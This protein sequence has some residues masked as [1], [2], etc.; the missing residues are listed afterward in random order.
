MPSIK[1]LDGGH[2]R[3]QLVSDIAH[4]AA[5]GL[6]DFFQ[7]A[8]HGV[9]GLGQLGQ[10]IVALHGHAGG[11]ISPPPNFFAAS[12]MRRSGVVM[13]LVSTMESTLDTISISPAG[14]DERREQVCQVFREAV[15]VCPREHKALEHAL[16]PSRMGL[17]AM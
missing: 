6:V 9:K 11:K 3:A 5:A 16:L 8:G 13:R 1:P 15:G 10:L 14:E 17:P 2:G 4:E 7:A 12:E